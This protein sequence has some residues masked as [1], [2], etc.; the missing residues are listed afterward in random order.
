MY[1]TDAR[2]LGK[3]AQHICVDIVNRTFQAEGEGVHQRNYRIPDN[4]DIR[5]SDLK[6]VIGVASVHLNVASKHEWWEFRHNSHDEPDEFT[7]SRF[8]LIHC[9]VVNFGGAYIQW[10]CNAEGK[11]DRRGFH[12]DTEDWLGGIIDNQQMES[13]AYEMSSTE[14][15]GR[16]D[17]YT[18]LWPWL[19][20][21][22]D[23][24]TG[25]LVQ[26]RQRAE[27]SKPSRWTAIPL[28]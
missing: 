21:V 13:V 19:I 26:A 2:E 23:D 17:G 12:G 28:N 22:L 20:R 9:G 4:Y 18:P 14:E 5:I 25:A 10:T 3:M 16:E 27:W 1:L 8:T 11:H 6:E 7:T 24:E 15:F